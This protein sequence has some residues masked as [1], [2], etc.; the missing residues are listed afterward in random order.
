M[1]VACWSYR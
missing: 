1:Q